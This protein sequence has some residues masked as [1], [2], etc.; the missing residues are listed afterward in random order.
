MPS[1]GDLVRELP[2]RPERF[3]ATPDIIVYPHTT[4]HPAH[5]VA[6]VKLCPRLCFSET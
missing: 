5:N 3:Q 2:R 4:L 1:G 6:T